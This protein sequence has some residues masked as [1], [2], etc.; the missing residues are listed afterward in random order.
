MGPTSVPD[1]ITIRR[2]REMLGW[3]RRKLG[4]KL[5]LTT[6]QMYALEGNIDPKPRKEKRMY[7]MMYIEFLGYAVRT[8]QDWPVRDLT[9]DLKYEQT[10]AVRLLNDWMIESISI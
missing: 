8:Y 5:G 4:S 3:T 1:H 2:T 10:R 7:P 6:R 9:F